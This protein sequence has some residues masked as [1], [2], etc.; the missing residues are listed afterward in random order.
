M[1]EL[2]IGING[3][4]CHS[5]ILNLMVLWSVREDSEGSH[6]SLSHLHCNQKS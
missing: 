5:R 6:C 1:M 2:F 3:L 4:E